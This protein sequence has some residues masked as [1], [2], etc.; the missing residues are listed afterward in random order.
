MHWQIL[1]ELHGDMIN[2]EAMKQHVNL[3]E[4]I[5]IYV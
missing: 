4:P 3:Q 1:L 2:S 5:W